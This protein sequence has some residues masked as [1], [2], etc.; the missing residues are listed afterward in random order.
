MRELEQ[1]RGIR[2]PFPAEIKV[3]E[4][5][6]DGAVVEGILTGFVRQIERVGDSVHP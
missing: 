2:Y 6:E 3:T 5:P 1:G 4:L